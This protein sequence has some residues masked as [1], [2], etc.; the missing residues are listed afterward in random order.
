LQE[1]AY[2]PSKSIHDVYQ[3]AVAERMISIK[4]NIARE[5]RQNGIQTVLTLPEELSINTIN[6]YLELKAKGAI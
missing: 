1:L 3:S 6:K 2:Q 5:L 4:S